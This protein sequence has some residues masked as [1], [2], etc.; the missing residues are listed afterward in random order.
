MINFDD[1]TKENLKEHNANWLQ[2]PHHPYR[3][4]T[5]GRSGSGKT[6]SLFNGISCQPDTDKIYSYALDPHE[7]KYQLLINKRESVGF[8][9]LN[10][11]K[12]FIEYSNYKILFCCTKIY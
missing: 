9:H 1:V 7:V 10:D 4:L 8:K 12:A 6:N 3:I 11:S 5:I 2:I